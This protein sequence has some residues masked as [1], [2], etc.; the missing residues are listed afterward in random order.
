MNGHHD[1]GAPGAPPAPED[2]V[3]ADAED[4]EDLPEMSMISALLLLTVVTVLVAF[5]SEFLVRPSHRDAGPFAL[6]AG[7]SRSVVGPRR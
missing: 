3:L 1:G 5:C 6:P 2:D 4:E 7:S